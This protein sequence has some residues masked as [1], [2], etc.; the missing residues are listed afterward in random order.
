M[1]DGRMMGARMPLHRSAIPAGARPGQAARFKIELRDARRQ[2]SA[3]QRL[4]F[5]R[6]TFAV[7]LLVSFLV[8]FT[9]LLHGQQTGKEALRTADAVRRL[10]P[11]QAAK[12]LPVRLKAVVTFHDD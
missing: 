4:R 7:P 10:S 8:P 9:P 5:N 11:E 6:A 2:R 3:L 1:I 12:H